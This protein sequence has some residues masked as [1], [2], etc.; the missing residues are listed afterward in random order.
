L[1]RATS[2]T[3]ST[4]REPASAHHARWPMRGVQVTYLIRF[5]ER[6][7]ATPTAMPPVPNALQAAAALARYRDAAQR[8][9]RSAWAQQRIRLLAELCS[10]TGRL[11][12]S[13]F[14]KSV[15]GCAVDVRLP[16]R[17][18]GTRTRFREPSE[19]KCLGPPS[20]G[21][22]RG[23]TVWVLKL[24]RDGWNVLRLKAGRLPET[25]YSRRWPFSVG[26]RSLWFAERNWSCKCSDGSNGQHTLTMK[27]IGSAIRG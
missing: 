16:L 20:R 6:L 1:V 22:G 17:P 15:Q 18:A 4:S 19:K 14:W 12:G 24:G 11:L 23:P 3:T 8:L 13:K 27:P 21:K 10:E 7:L 9:V 25:R 2:R 26:V 5:P